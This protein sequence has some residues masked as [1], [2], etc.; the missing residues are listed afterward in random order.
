MVDYFRRCLALAEQRQDRSM[1]ALCLAGLAGAARALARPQHAARL[2]GAAES[3]REAAGVRIDLA[4]REPHERNVSE[5]R[6]AL[7]DDAFRTAWDAGREMAL[8]QALAEARRVDSTAP[9]ERSPT[10]RAGLLSRR[11]REV[12][13]LVARGYTNRQ[14]AEE[15]TIAERTVGTHVEHIMAKLRCHARAQIAAWVVEHGTQ[16]RPG[17][18]RV[19]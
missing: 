2:F 10:G 7:S 19:A 16:P 9:P 14:I 4:D 1:I 3:L 11:E 13:V 8:D 15:L 18:R 12:A 17:P 5:T 6:R